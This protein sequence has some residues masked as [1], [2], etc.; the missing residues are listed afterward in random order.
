V[1]GHSVGEI[2]AA[3]GS[4]VLSAE[5]AMVFVPSGQGDG[6]C[7]ARTQTGMTAVLGG[8]PQDFSRAARTR[9]DASEH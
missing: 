7:A 3:V 1:P 5:Q 2:T 4:G 8:E 6:R 9:I